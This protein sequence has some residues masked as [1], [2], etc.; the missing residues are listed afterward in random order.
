[1]PEFDTVHEGWLVNNHNHQTKRT[2][3][4]LE[5]PC[6]TLW[7]RMLY[8]CVLLLR[9]YAAWQ[10][11]AYLTLAVRYSSSV[12]GRDRL[13]VAW[14][15]SSIPFGALLRALQCVILVNGSTGELIAIRP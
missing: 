8:G 15:C 9:P 3:E 11:G 4:D 2:G 5:L 7:Q 10:V 12:P 1:M 6:R 14:T 13:M